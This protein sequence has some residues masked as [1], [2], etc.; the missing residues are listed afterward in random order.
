M[1]I[2]FYISLFLYIANISLISTNIDPDFWARI[3][4]GKTFFQT[5][6]LLNFDFQSFGPTRQWFDHEWGASLIFYSILDK[7]GD[8]GIITFK[9]VIVF[10]TYFILTRIILLRRKYI[11]KSIK[12]NPTKEASFNIIFFILLTQYV[13][14]V[15]N[16]TV[17]CHLFTF[18]FF[19]IWLYVL[20][21]SRLEN[22][23]KILWLLPVSMIIW[24]NI[25][26]GCF[27]GLGLLTLY[28]IGEYL[29]KKPIKPYVTTL[30]FSILALFV[31]PYGAEYV[32]FLFHAITL[33]RP[34]ITEWQ[35]LFSKI[36]FAHY[37]KF[38]L[39]LMG[40]TILSSIILIRNYKKQQNKDFKEKLINTYNSLDKTKAIILIAM[41]FLS[42]K[43]LR[44][45]I[46]FAFCATVFLYDDIYLKLLNKKLS[47]KI[48]NLKEILLFLLISI[49]LVYTVKTKTI[50]TS[51]Q[52]FPYVEAEFLKINHLKGNLLANF[53]YGSFLAYKLYP[54]NFIFMD[55]RYEETYDPAL[56]ERLNIIH[57]KDNWKEELNRFHVDY[58]IAE[59][60]YNKLCKHLNEDKD[61]K[62]ILESKNFILFTKM[63]T[64]LKDFKIP[65]SD[66]KY[67]QKHK[68][69]TNI[70]WGM[71][72]K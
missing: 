32:Y 23:Y 45:I 46:F 30:A 17:R 47:N 14:N 37:F 56:L 11:H 6:T 20:E 13:L 59:K 58:I 66:F 15:V 10:V 51:I 68:W 72:E 8:V 40:M 21:K 39:W 35:P 19:V 49:S 42:F 18:L 69:D 12:I 16:S 43:S 53:H 38:K 5:G 50:E 3:I 9:I 4:V 29:N 60:F 26:G 44:L 71:N 63:N 31:N 34:N 65:S 33:S 1:I 57:T 55:G 25:H 64:S 2:V 41:F 36:H 62:P 67:Y 48:N 7:F 52:E 27:T 70:N 22:N 28:I 54:N 61:W 24:S